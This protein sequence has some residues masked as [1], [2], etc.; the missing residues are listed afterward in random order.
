MTEI[1]EQISSVFISLGIHPV[2][3]G[4]LLGILLMILL[5]RKKSADTS[6]SYGTHTGHQNWSNPTAGLKSPG[7][8][9]GHTSSAVTTSIS[10]KSTT[11]NPEISQKILQLAQSGNI[12]QAIKELRTVTGLGLKE[13]KDMVE[14]M[15]RTKK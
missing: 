14:M 2:G 1:L 3:G 6:V 9:H 5:R 8:Q 4:F 15:N 7:L 11:L 13:A 12:I 10:T